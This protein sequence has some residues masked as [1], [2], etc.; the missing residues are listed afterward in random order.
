MQAVVA[1]CIVTRSTARRAYLKKRIGVTA[2]DIIEEI[3]GYMAQFYEEQS[4]THK[5]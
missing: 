3:P 2:P 4:D 5:L 1:A